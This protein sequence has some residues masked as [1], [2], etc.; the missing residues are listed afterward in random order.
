MDASVVAGDRAA[1]IP[2]RRRTAPR[3]FSAACAGLASVAL[4]VGLAVW[5]GGRASA[6]IVVLALAAAGSLHSILIWFAPDAVPSLIGR[7]SGFGG[8]LFQT[9]WAPQHVASAMCVVLV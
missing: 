5:I 1:R 7:A 6:A 3:C 9:S 4:L 2:H 8:W